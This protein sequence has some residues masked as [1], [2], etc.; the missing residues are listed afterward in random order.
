MKTSFPEKMELF[1]IALDPVHIG[2]GGYRLGGVEN[3]IVRDPATDVPKIPGTSL[4][5][6][7]R[8]YATLHLMENDGECKSRNVDE[9]KRKCAERKIAEYFGD[10]NRQ[11]LARIHDAEILFFP[12]SSIQGTTWI[13][14]VSLL[15]ELENESGKK[16]IPEKNDDEAYALKG[17]DTSKPVNLGWLL[18]EFKEMPD[19]KVTLPPKLN[20]FIR[21]LVTVPDVLFSQII[22]D[23]LEV[24]TSV[25]ID[26]ITGTAKSEALF[27]YEAIPRG[28]VFHLEIVVDRRRD[29]ANGLEGLI[30][31]TF[32]YLRLL[33]IGGM[34][35]RGFGR[36]DVFRSANNLQRGV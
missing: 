12:V 29:P 21:R 7:I 31:A 8:E 19:N 35:T 11:G 15:N 33:G 28:T 26:P 24:R 18:L 32:P 16:V 3:T 17:V 22:N 25:R 9:D 30:E 36:I 5:G 1:G 14:T 20:E 34:G 2:T 13:T 6:V 27:A 10:E 4:A 23:N